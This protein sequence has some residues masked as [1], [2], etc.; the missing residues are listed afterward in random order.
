MRLIFCALFI[1]L[2][3][4]SAVRAQQQPQPDPFAGNLFP[5]ELL[6][7]HQQ[8]LSLSEEQKNFLSA[9]LSK[10]QTRVTELQWDLQKEVEKLAVL[11]KQDQVDE[12]QALTQLDKVLSLEREIKRAHIGLLIRI[13]NKL[14]PEQLAKLREI[15][16]KS[17]GR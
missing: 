11:M 16:G 4:F 5:P 15:Q 6:M 9:E 8:A 10:L 2:S 1:L 7:R 12:A 14:D 17:P 3:S 13:K